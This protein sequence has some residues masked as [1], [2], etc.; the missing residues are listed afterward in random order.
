MADSA[1][2]VNPGQRSV[3]GKPVTT[4]RAEYLANWVLSHTSKIHLG[5]QYKMTPYLED[6]VIAAKEVLEEDETQRV[7]EES[8]S[9]K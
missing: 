7:L 2:F 6:A 5:A 8:Q 1:R 4:P 3:R 9:G